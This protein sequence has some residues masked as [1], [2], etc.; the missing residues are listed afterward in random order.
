[1]N[2]PAAKSYGVSNTSRIEA[3]FGVYDPERFTQILAD[4]PQDFLSYRMRGNVYDNNLG[5]QQKA[6]GD[7]MQAARLGDNIIQSY[8]DSLE[9][10]WRDNPAP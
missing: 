10:K 6:I 3:R 4:H 1:M 7:W 2:Y 5:D 8:L 9:I